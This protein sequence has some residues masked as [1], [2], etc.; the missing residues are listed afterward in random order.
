MYIN[1]TCPPIPHL[2]VGGISVYRKG[3]KHERRS[4]HKTFDLMYVHKGCLYMDEAGKRFDIHEGEFLILAPER[5]HYGYQ[6]CR[7]D[8]VFYWVHLY[9]EGEYSYS[10]ELL[11]YTATKMNK[12]KYYHR[13]TFMISL[14]QFGTIGHDRQ[15]KMKGYLEKISLVKIDR[16]NQQKLF[17]DS[18]SSQ[19]NYQILFMQI[20]SIICEVSPSPVKNDIAEDIHE[21]LEQTYADPFSL[22]QLSHRFS[23]HPLYITRCVKQKYGRTPLQLLMKIRMEEAKKLLRTTNLNVNI[24]GQKVGYADAA[25]FSKQ[26]KKITGMT[27]KEYRTNK[28]DSSMV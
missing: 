26:F 22:T 5:L 12:N 7:E 20:L 8:T 23:F 3:D 28:Q 11:P 24:I 21:Y 19:I 1:F 13:D 16:Y 6:Y 2:I 10:N 17:F 14:P 25:Y 18:I 9:T 4:I 27:A 15:D